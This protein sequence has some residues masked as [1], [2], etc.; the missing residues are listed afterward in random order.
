[1]KV[2]TTGELHLSILS[3]KVE[4]YYIA[5]EKENNDTFTGD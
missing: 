2:T 5:K 1:L 4:T 3:A